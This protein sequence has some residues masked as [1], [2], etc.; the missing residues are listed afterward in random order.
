LTVLVAPNWANVANGTR[1]PDLNNSTRPA[2]PGLKSTP[3]NIRAGGPYIEVITDATIGKALHCHVPAGYV[4]DEGSARCEFEP[5]VP[6]I[7]VGQTIWYGFDFRTSGYG[8]QPWG[9]SHQFKNGGTGGPPLAMTWNSNERGGGLRIDSRGTEN[10]LLAS[11]STSWRRIVF[12]CV[13]GRTGSARVEVW[14]DGVQVVNDTDWRA[15]GDSGANT[16]A[17]GLIYANRSDA[18][19]KFGIYAATVNFARSNYFANMIVA[20]TRAEVMG[21][22]TGGG[23]GGG[24]TTRDA[25]T[26]V[27]VSVGDGVVNLNLGD[28]TGALAGDTRQLYYAD[29]TLTTGEAFTPNTPVDLAIPLNTT[30][31]QVTGLTNGRQYFFRQSV[32][33]A[34]NYASWGGPAEFASATPGVAAILTVSTLPSQTATAGGANPANTT[35]TVTNTGSAAGNADFT[36]S[37][38]ASWL[39]VT[40]AGGG[41]TGTYARTFDRVDDRIVMTLDGL[42]SNGGTFFALVRKNQNVDASPIGL[43][44]G[45]TP[46]YFLRSGDNADWA[47]A[48]WDNTAG[49]QGL[50]SAVKQTPSTWVLLVASKASGSPGA[51]IGSMYDFTAGTWNHG[52]GSVNR[53]AFTPTDLTIGNATTGTGTTLWPGEIAVCGVVPIVVSQANRELMV[54]SGLVTLATLAAAGFTS[55]NGAKV[56]P[57]DQASTATAVTDA[58]GGSTQT[59]ITGTSVHSGGGVPFLRTAGGG[60][61]SGTASTTGTTVTQAYN[62]SGLTAG[63]YNATVTVDPADANL[64]NITRT[65]TLVVN[66]AGATTPT[67]DFDGT[68]DRIIA[69]LG[70]NNLTG[71]WT[72][73]VGCR[74]DADS[75]WGPL[76]VIENSAGT[77]VQVGIFIAD[78]NPGRPG[79]IWGTN[80]NALASAAGTNVQQ[81]DGWVIV[82][83]SKASGSVAPRGHVYKAGAWTHADM[84]T[85]VANQASFAGGRVVFGSSL[86]ANFFNGKIGFAYIFNGTALSDSQ[87]EALDGGSKSTYLALG[88]SGGWEFNQSAVG[89]SVTD[90]TGNGADQTAITG[91][92][93]TTSDAPASSVYVFT[94]PGTGGI[95]AAPQNLA[96]TNVTAAGA[97]DLTWTASTGPSLHATEPYVIETSTDTTTWSQNSTSNTTSKTVTGLT[98]G[99]T[100]Y[101]R[102]RAKNTNSQLSDPAAASPEYVEARPVATQT[103]LTG[104]IGTAGEGLITMQWN[105]APAN[106]G[107]T[108]YRIYIRVTGA[109]SFPSSPS[110]AGSGTLLPSGKLQ[111]AVEIDPGS[112]QATVRSFRP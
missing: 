44:A 62:T 61:S 26:P 58:V 47:V 22:T 83:F 41:G 65:S 27:V 84:A 85:A 105:P 101:L 82:A 35:F 68:D 49:G 111:A 29:S 98:V 23:G 63:T 89:T 60:G 52:T 2:L 37:D 73:I 96:V 70:N 31:Y 74:K 45:A 43:S 21:T 4:S 57:L 94:D 14:V 48:Y 59:S 9:A 103:A 88:P 109:G 99:S 77:A 3:H 1:A 20:T 110:W 40:V 19:L 56:F 106:Q 66:S 104:V 76:M 11:T 78:T 50:D 90:L 13:A 30:T 36:V 53:T 10:Y 15:P 92:T 5:N 18:Y 87:F 97:A 55:G 100:T 28:V 32:G 24:G 25:D 51:I 6:N 42:T 75:I 91:T 108:E 39:T 7:T 34:G 69:S 67:R 86:A 8:G 95:P 33:Q 112:Y 17:G 93:V 72:M 12:G 81:A 54:S 64:S 107:I 102:V 38:D 71:A 79:V 16:G 80:S 46:Q